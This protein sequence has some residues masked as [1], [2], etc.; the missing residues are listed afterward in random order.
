MIKI[1]PKTYQLLLSEKRNP[2]KNPSIQ[3]T[4]FNNTPPKSTKKWKNFKRQKRALEGGGLHSVLGI[5]GASTAT[6]LNRKGRRRKR[7]QRRK[8]ER[9]GGGTRCRRRRAAMG[10][11]KERGGGRRGKTPDLM[12]PKRS[13]SAS[14]P[15]I[16]QYG[17]IH[18]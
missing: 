5:T 12:E 9:A 3:Q 14:L 6:R 15:S 4:F 7:E 16:Q 11:S 13:L 8:R 1:L 2:E 17:S 18:M 10:G